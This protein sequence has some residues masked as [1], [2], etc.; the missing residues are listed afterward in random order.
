MKGVV[1]GCDAWASELTERGTDS[2]ARGAAEK[3]NGMI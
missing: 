3:P 2:T 1:D